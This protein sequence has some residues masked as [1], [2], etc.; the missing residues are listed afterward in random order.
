MKPVQQ[1]QT[2]FVSADSTKPRTPVRGNRYSNRVNH[3]DRD[4]QLR[5]GVPKTPS[6]VLKSLQVILLLLQKGYYMPGM[7]S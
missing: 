6:A 4:L 3:R 5:V 1:S 2:F 7:V